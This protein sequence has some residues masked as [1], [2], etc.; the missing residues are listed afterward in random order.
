M[1]RYCPSCANELRGLRLR[2]PGCHRSMIGW[3]HISVIAAL[4]VIGILF[5][6]K[7]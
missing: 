2:C 5:M 6:L 7:P 1:E 3:L 4:D